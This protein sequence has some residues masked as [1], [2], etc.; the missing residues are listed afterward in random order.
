MDLDVANRLETDIDEALG[1][2]DYPLAEALAIEYRA[3]AEREDDAAPTAQSPR[4]RSRWL[5]AQ[6]A[7][8]VGHLSEAT[9]R[10]SPLLPP[11]TAIDASPAAR[12]VLA[13]AAALARLG[14]HEQARGHLPRAREQMALTRKVPLL[15]ELRAL[16]IALWL[17]AVAE[18]APGLA[19][20]VLDLEASGE[21]AN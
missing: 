18:S 6:V 15:L 21:H 17:G 13:S 10:R 7:L 12:S 11:P 14:R 19:S 9:R 3:A 4:F 1:R 2:G 5:A 20:C 8:A 16:R